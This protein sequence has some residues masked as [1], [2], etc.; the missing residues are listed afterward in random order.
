M[1]SRKYKPSSNRW[2]VGWRGVVPIEYEM[3]EFRVVATPKA[4]FGALKA[5]FFDELLL[6]ACL[7]MHLFSYLFFT[8]VL[9][10]TFG[11]IFSLSLLSF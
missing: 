11:H 4:F 8:A 9:L 7:V 6:I 2:F 1:L 5:Q 3:E 10:C